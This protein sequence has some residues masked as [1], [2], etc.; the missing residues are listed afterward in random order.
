MNEV[1][2]I[3]SRIELGEAGAAGLLYRWSMTN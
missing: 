3:L 1:T 2:R